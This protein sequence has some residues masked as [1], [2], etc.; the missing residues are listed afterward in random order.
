MTGQPQETTTFKPGD[1]AMETIK[2]GVGSAVAGMAYSSILDAVQ[3]NRHGWLSIS[4]RTSGAVK[5]F[6][7]CFWGYFYSSL[8]KS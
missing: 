8:S 5:A 4:K 3:G 7:K 2:I 1:C 6:G